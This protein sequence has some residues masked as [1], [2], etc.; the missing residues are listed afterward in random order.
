MGGFD[1]SLPACEDY[2]LW[3]RISLRCPIHLLDE[4]LVVKRGGHADQL[5]RA[6]GLDKFRIRALEKIITGGRLTHKQYIAALD[7]MKQKCS[8]YASGCMRRGRVDEAHYYNAL[9]GRLSGKR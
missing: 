1:V 7:M 6:P 9:P 3:L 5:S 4:P 8:I 2:D